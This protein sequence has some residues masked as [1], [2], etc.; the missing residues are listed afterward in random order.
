MNS[1]ETLT[2]FLGW[3]TI[4]NVGM[5]ALAAISVMAMHGLMARIHASMFGVSEAD[6]PRVY[7]NYMAQYQIGI[8]VFNLAPYIALK[9][10]A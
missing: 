1:L 6:L 7:F 3:C 8:F 2:E 5:L 9:L 4:L 10:M